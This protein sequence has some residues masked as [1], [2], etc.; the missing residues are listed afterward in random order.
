MRIGLIHARRF[1][2]STA[3]QITTIKA[4]LDAA[5][6]HMKEDQMRSEQWRSGYYNVQFAVNI[7]Y[8]AGVGAFPNRS[9]KTLLKF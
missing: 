1:W 2:K 8:I 5:F 7:K 3:K 4:E 6:M 9:P